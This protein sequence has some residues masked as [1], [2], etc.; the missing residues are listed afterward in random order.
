MR[1]RLIA[2]AFSIVFSVSHS[3]E[4]IRVQG[5]AAILKSEN[6]KHFYSIGDVL[7]SQYSQEVKIV[8]FKKNWVLVDLIKGNISVGDRL[9]LHSKKDGLYKDPLSSE[10]LSSRTDLNSSRQW[11]PRKIREKFD[12]TLQ[13]NV[14]SSSNSA[15]LDQEKSE[16]TKKGKS[17]LLGFSLHFQKQEDWSYGIGG[18]LSRAQS[19]FSDQFQDSLSSLARDEIDPNANVIFD[20]LDESKLEIYLSG[21]KR[22][23]EFFY[24]EMAGIFSKYS[25]KTPIV[26]DISGSIIPINYDFNFS[27]FGLGVGFGG[28]YYISERWSVGA[29]LQYV[30][31]IYSSGEQTVETNGVNEK[32]KIEGSAT[33]N[34]LNG[35]FSLGYSF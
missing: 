21:R 16:I 15:L 25:L 5:S 7:V 33:Q 34:S 19:E 27:G 3:A 23:T 11:S 6:L 35:G 32:E 1:F 17:L 12:N 2:I 29:S 22:L 24:F 26:I 10:S 13:L 31:T 14:F 28:E 9:N 30:R 18:R 4:V 20:N 8:K